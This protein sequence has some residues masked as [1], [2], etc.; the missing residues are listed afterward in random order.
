M[1]NSE[2]SHCTLA[3]WQNYRG[4]LIISIFWLFLKN[5][6]VSE[7]TIYRALVHVVLCS[8]EKMHEEKNSSDL[9]FTLSIPILYIGFKGEV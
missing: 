5:G 6:S 1:P 7:Q 2:I 9:I 8:I 3:T 4:T